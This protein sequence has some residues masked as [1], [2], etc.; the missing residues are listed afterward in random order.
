MLKQQRFR[1]EKQNAFNEEVNKIVL[2]SKDD[3]KIPEQVEIQ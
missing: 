3:K 2:S 1:S